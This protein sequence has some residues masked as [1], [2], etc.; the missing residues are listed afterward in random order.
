MSRIE[1]KLVLGTVGE[2]PVFER[3]ASAASA[4]LA[5]SISIPFESGGGIVAVFASQTSAKADIVGATL[6]DV[7]MVSDDQFVDSFG[8]R[9]SRLF[10]ANVEPGIYQ[11]RVV[12]A[13]AQSR[14]YVS[15][16]G[17]RVQRSAVVSGIVHRALIDGESPN[18]IVAS[19]IGDLVVAMFHSSNSGFSMQWADPAL[20][21]QDEKPGGLTFPEVFVADQL[22]AQSVTIQGIAT[23]ASGALYSGVAFNIGDLL[24]LP[25][26]QSPVFDMSPLQFVNG[27]PGVVDLA[28]RA[29][30]PDGD[31]IVISVVSGLR[32]ELEGAFHFDHATFVLNYDGRDVLGSPDDQIELDSGIVLKADDGRP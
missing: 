22:G 17:W 21:H 28:L 11:C 29:S 24:P 2:V 32:P 27:V 5:D 1:V 14:P 20:E 9:N 16:G 8:A 6:N 23:P 25:T 4:D 10:W 26:N 3:A 15:C 31:P 7:P 30:D 13:N 18:A 12:Y 19:R